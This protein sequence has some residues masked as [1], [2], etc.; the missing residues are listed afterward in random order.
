MDYRPKTTADGS[1]GTPSDSVEDETTYGLSP[2]AG[3]SAEYSRGDHTHGTPTESAGVTD[4]G[5][6]TGLADDDH[7]QYRLES[8]DHSHASTG[9][10]GGTVDHGALTGLT[11]DDHTQYQKESEKGQASGYASLD[12]GALVPT[13]ELGTG[14]ADDTV[15]LRG[16]QTWA[17]PIQNIGAR[18]YHNAAQTLTSGTNTILNFNSELYDVGDL[19]DTATNNSRLTAPVAGKYLIFGNIAFAANTTGLREL[20]LLL[21][22]ITPIGLARE[23]PQSANH[24]MNC[25]VIYDLAVGDYIQCTVN[26]TSGGNLNVVVAG[27]ASPHFGMTLVQQAGSA[28][29]LIDLYQ[30]PFESL[31]Q[32]ATDVLADPSTL[33]NL[34]PLGLY[35]IISGSGALNTASFVNTNSGIDI[36][37]GATSGGYAGLYGARNDTAHRTTALSTV[38]TKVKWQSAPIDTNLVQRMEL[39]G[40]GN[41][42]VN[43]T[44]YAAAGASLFVGFRIDVAG[45]NETLKA[46]TK[47]GAS[48]TVT[49]TGVT[50]VLDVMNLFEIIASSSQ[51]KFYIDGNLVATHTT[52]IPTGALGPLWSSRTKE[53][54][55]K[56]TQLEWVKFSGPRI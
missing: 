11:D 37:S 53:N 26:Q 16:D 45:S 7:T 3:V 24:F 6:L 4:H 21:N 46:V 55:A 17:N 47:N 27:D 28:S 42:L 29:G 22:G 10:Q 18:V 23:V 20:R 1:G 15:F 51:V 49:D 2:D 40:L 33:A 32:F 48:E 35:G 56:G 5:A 31:Y 14:T 8:E 13:D 41:S 12:A 44:N 52:N 54:A 25:S 30:L 50:Q 43:G 38:P 9:L 34:I 36:H 39:L 19:H